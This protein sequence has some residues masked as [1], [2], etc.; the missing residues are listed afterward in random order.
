MV[1]IYVIYF[2]STIH[3]NL[4][5]LLFPLLRRKIPLGELLLRE[6]PHIFDAEDDD[7]WALAALHVI[8]AK[9][10]GRELRGKVEGYEAVTCMQTKIISILYTEYH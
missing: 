5:C 8:A 7:F 6:E 9:E 10:E 3:L 4:L 2:K 1:M